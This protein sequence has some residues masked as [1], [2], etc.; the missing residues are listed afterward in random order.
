MKITPKKLLTVMKQNNLSGMDV[1]RKINVSHLT[2]YSFLKGKPVRT[3]TTE[4]I[5]GLIKR[6]E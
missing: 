5:A 6:Y 4:A 1:S 3:K 2:V